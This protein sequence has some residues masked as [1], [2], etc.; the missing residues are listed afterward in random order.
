M[1]PRAAPIHGGTNRPDRFAEPDHDRLPHQEVTDIEL[2][3][4]WQGR[5]G[6]GSLIVQA[7]TRMDFEAKPGRNLGALANA[8][9]LRLRSTHA[10]FRERV[11]PGPG[12]N[13]DHR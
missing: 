6:L 7:M 4:L 10:A 9:E 2:N 8:R 5:N 1:N 12:V 13:L 11:A 3:E